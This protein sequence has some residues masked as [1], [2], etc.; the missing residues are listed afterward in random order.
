MT[1]HPPASAMIPNQSA[2]HSV[3]QIGGIPVEFPHKAYGSQLAFMGRVISTLDRAQRQGHC[4]ALLESP[5]GTG[6]TLSLLCSALAWQKSFLSRYPAPAPSPSQAAGKDGQQQLSSEGSDPLVA[7]GG[8]IPESE[9]SED[10]S[11]KPAKS[12]AQQ[13]HAPPT[14]YYASRTHAQLSQVISEYR[15]TSYRVRMAILVRIRC[16]KFTDATV[17]CGTVKFFK[18]LLKDE[19]LGCVEF[20]NANK[21]KDHPSIKRG[22]DYEVHD[23]E[24]LVKVGRSVKGCSYFGALSIAGDAELVFCPYSYA[25]N[26]LIR[27]AMDIDLKGDILILDEAHNIEDMTREAAS[28]DI[29][30]EILHSN[31]SVARL[32]QELGELS[33]GPMADRATYQ[34]LHDMIQVSQDVHLQFL[35]AL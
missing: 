34:P 18:E 9:S 26:P 29:D 3:Y 13:K 32:Q 1:K 12:G 25:V 28:V 11:N 7:G 33:S 24:D 22:G 27:K 14:I 30:E 17:S 2:K 16:F 5:T 6:K 21:V 23:I 20:K 10:P 8:F 35:Y 4:H 31:I 19:E 15:K